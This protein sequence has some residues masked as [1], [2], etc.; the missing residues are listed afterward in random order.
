MTVIGFV[1]GMLLLALV[2]FALMLAIGETYRVAGRYIGFA[3][4]ALLVVFVLG[5]LLEPYATRN[6][7]MNC[8]VIVRDLL[9]ALRD[10]ALGLFRW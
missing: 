4:A 3:C 9:F 5:L 8:I 6:M 1:T 7:A 10:V 2:G